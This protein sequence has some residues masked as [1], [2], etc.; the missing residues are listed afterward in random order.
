MRSGVGHQ[1][2]HP[3]EVCSLVALQQFFTVNSK[4]NSLTGA[5]YYHTG[6]HWMSY[7]MG[8]KNSN[9]IYVPTG[10]HPL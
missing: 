5:N 3:A 9:Y 7:A 2:I 4:V 1:S 6:A 8:G 10:L